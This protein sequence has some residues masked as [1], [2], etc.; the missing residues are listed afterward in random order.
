MWNEEQGEGANPT[1]DLGTGT[2]GEESC[3]Y[4]GSVERT[5]L[6]QCMPRTAWASEPQSRVLMTDLAGAARRS[7]AR[8]ESKSGQLAKSS[9]IVDRYR[10]VRSVKPRRPWHSVVR[11]QRRL[12]APHSHFR[13]RGEN[14]GWEVRLYP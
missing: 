13:A 1:H 10:E 7:A 5:W 3:T 8:C 9:E 11:C 12:V 6:H 4:E 14:L 2:P